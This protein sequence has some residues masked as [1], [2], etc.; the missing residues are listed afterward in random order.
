MKRVGKVC[1]GK[2]EG[3]LV[4]KEDKKNFFISLNNIKINII[5]LRP[6]PNYEIDSTYYSM[7]DREAKNTGLSIGLGGFLG[8]MAFNGIKGSVSHTVHWLSGGYSNFEFD[9]ADDED[10]SLEFFTLVHVM[11]YNETFWKNFLYID[12]LYKQE[13]TALSNWLEKNR[14]NIIYEQLNYTDDISQW[15]KNS[16]YF[17]CFLYKIQVYLLFLDNDIKREIYSFE[18]VIA[19][20]NKI[21][22]ADT[23]E[24][25]KSVVFDY[26]TKMKA[27]T[28]IEHGGITLEN[29]GKK[30]EQFEG[31]VN[32]FSQFSDTVSKYISECKPLMEIATYMFKEEFKPLYNLVQDNA[33]KLIE[34]T[35]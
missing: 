23:T 10:A 12:S 1:Y 31:Y 8:L 29:I 24:N 21:A 28:Y 27:T 20:I 7:S 3:G 6:D 9:N 30:V 34:S 17:E 25:L 18:E 26:I 22:D 35:N 14:K 13:S 2:Y 5:D 15:I 11:Q 4:Y 33:K 16:K 19:I 32:N